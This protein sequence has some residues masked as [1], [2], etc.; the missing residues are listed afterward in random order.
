MCSLSMQFGKQSHWWVKKKFLLSWFS[1]FF[2]FFNVDILFSLAGLIFYFN[3]LFYYLIT[4]SEEK[5]LPPPTSRLGTRWRSSGWS[6]GCYSMSRLSKSARAPPPGCIL[7]LRKMF[8]FTL[9]G[10]FFLGEKKHGE[11]AIPQYWSVFIYR[12]VPTSPVL[13]HIVLKPYSD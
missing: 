2:F 10:R 5:V 13:S 3:Y 8:F 7:P 1:T 12:R 4:P 6:S 9:D 11:L